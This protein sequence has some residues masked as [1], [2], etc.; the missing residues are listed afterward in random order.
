L[1]TATDFTLTQPCCAA[2]GAKRSEDFIPQQQ[3][4]DHFEISIY[5]PDNRNEQCSRKPSD[6][7]P[8]TKT[9]PVS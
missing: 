6:V 3:S 9:I 1:S 8:A 2:R 5:N 4:A 7:C